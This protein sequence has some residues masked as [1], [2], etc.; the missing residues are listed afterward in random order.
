MPRPPGSD[1]Q[2]WE[3][4]DRVIALALIISDRMQTVKEISDEPD[5]LRLVLYT[6]GDA[7]LIQKVARDYRPRLELLKKKS[8]PVGGNGPAEAEGVR[9]GPL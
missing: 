7:L 4:L 3:F 9:T 5:V 6:E 2:D 8:R 1:D